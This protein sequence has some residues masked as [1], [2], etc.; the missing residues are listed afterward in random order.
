MTINKLAATISALAVITGAVVWPLN[1]FQ[2]K[3]EAAEQVQ[4]QAKSVNELRAEFYLKRVSEI[5]A[6]AKPTRAELD[7]KTL[8][9]EMVKAIQAEKISAKGAK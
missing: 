6:K 4:Q 1:F 5:N 3:A 2:S 7:E 8:L 9:M